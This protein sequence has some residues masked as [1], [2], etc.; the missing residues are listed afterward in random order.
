[1][2]T[3][4]YYGRRPPKTT[5]RML[6]LPPLAVGQRVFVDRS[7]GTYWMTVIGGRTMWYFWT[8]P[9]LRHRTILGG[10]KQ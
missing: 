3:W 9:K 4:T 5:R 8:P 10:I 6:S 2:K 7:T 1:M